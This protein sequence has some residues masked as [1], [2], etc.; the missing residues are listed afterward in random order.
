VPS[1]AQSPIQ[2]QQTFSLCHPISTRD[3]TLSK[4]SKMVNCFIE[5][6]ENGNTLVKR[7]GMQVDRAQSGTPQGTFNCNG[8]SYSIV[9]DAV[10]D[11]ISGTTV[12]IP[13]VTVFGQAYYSVNDVPY[14][15][16]LI[17]SASGLWKFA[18]NS[19]GSGGTFTKVTDANYPVTTAPGICELGGIIYV[20]DATPG[21]SG[22][23]R[24][25]N[26]DDPL[27]WPAL[28]F[29]QAD[30]TLGVAKGLYRHLNYLVAYYDRGVQMYYDANAAN[31]NTTQGTQLGPVTNASWTSGL[32][33]GDSVVEMTDLSFFL[34]Q[35]SKLGRVFIMIN[36]LEMQVISTPFV[37][38]ITELSNLNKVYSFGI[39]IV[40]HS[41]YVIT[42]ADLAVTLV[43]DVGGNQ[44]YQW[45]SMVNG[46]ETAFVGAYYLNGQ[47]KNYLQSTA[48]GNLLEMLP[49]LYQDLG[50]VINVQA[51]T[52][53]YDY[54]TINYKRIASLFLLGDNSNTSF[55]LDFSD[56]DYQTWKGAK[57]IS[58]LPT[59]K[60]IQRAG[61]F[62]RR[63]YR[64]T[65]QD[66]TP[67]RL[68]DGKLDVTLLSS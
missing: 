37:D 6:T 26:I 18:G 56:D 38:K 42:F 13:S 12:A 65:H 24:G 29:I 28:N 32:A 7:P 31:G 45:T 35:D 36:G 16:T 1:Q 66:N 41:F 21:T 17:K 60:M 53:I 46:V 5:V 3:G 20:M 30:F 23:V 34:A 47:G 25:S 4:D 9:N 57:V 19:D 27:T 14:G 64:M 63:A 39:R 61:R 22:N 58:C 52:A 10:T 40:G 49:N 54:G 50:G 15:T 2:P 51:V 67:L 11:V 55:T 33:A 62:R 44:W 68:A 59:R 43:Y 8:R 48:T